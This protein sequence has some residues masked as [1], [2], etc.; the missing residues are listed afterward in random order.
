MLS[1]LELVIRRKNEQNAR[2]ICLTTYTYNIHWSFN[3]FNSI[4]SAHGQWTYR[5]IRKKI[6]KVQNQWKWIWCVWEFLMYVQY[7]VGH[8]FT[9]WALTSDKIIR[10]FKLNQCMRK[11]RS[12][13]FV[14]TW[15]HLYWFYVCLWMYRIE[16]YMYTWY[17]IHLLCAPIQR[18]TSNNT[19]NTYYQKW[20]LIFR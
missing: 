14:C 6:R 7:C 19:Y 2:S 15:C 5:R 1:V 11:M 12:A 17:L 10:A 9:A 16:I 20:T 4:N 3:I 18:H 13:H 8:S